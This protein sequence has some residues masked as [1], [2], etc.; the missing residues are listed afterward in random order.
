MTDIL[1]L[2]TSRS[3]TTASS[4]LR[5]AYSS[6][7]NTTFEYSDEIRIL[8][9]QQDTLS[10]ESFLYIKGKLTKNKVVQSAHVTLGNNCVAFIFDEI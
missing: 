6:F 7:A 8:I 9:Q 4:R 2:K 5:F 1:T 3:S 10:Y